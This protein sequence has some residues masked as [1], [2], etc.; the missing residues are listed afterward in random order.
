MKIS[1]CD[2]CKTKSDEY[3]RKVFVKQKN[4]VVSDEYDICPTCMTIYDDIHEKL[5]GFRTTTKITIQTE[6]TNDIRS[7]DIVTSEDEEVF[8]SFSLDKKKEKVPEEYDFQTTEVI[9]YDQ[10]CRFYG[11]RIDRGWHKGKI[12]D[13]GYD[14]DDIPEE[15][16][17]TE[18]VKLSMHE[19]NNHTQ[20]YASVLEACKASGGKKIKAR[21][22]LI[23]GKT[24]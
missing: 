8:N 4:W 22:S 15:K 19:R 17:K 6:P 10:Q 24:N 9:K 16:E 21:P 13:R 7:L 20:L 18:A 11:Q 1:V 23:I 3:E 2:V 14:L 12:C 5:H